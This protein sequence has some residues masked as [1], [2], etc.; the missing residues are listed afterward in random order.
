MKLPRILIAAGASGS[1]K[2]LITCGILQA[3][4]NRGKK[5]ASFKCGPD[6]IDP[7]FHRR[8]IG[9]KAGNLDAFFVSG[10]P[11][12]ELLWQRSQA[13]D[14]AVIEG[15]MG[16]Y[17]GLGG[18]L[19][20]GSSYD[21]ARQ[22]ETPVLFV[23]NCRGMSLSILP[24]IQGFCQFRKDNG[25]GGILLNQISPMIYEKVKAAI[26][27]N[28]GL[29]VVGYLPKVEEYQI[30]S[31]HLGL[32][33]PDEV[34]NLK[35]KLMGLAAVMEKTVDFPLLLSIAEK[36]PPLFPTS[37]K[38]EYMA[39][40]TG[41]RPIRVAVARD[42]AFCFLYEENLDFLQKLGAEILEFSPLRDSRLPDDTE[43]LILYG[44]Y[45]ELFAAQL[46]ENSSLRMEI[47]NRCGRERLPLLAEC[48]GFMYLHDRMADQEGRLVQGVG[49][50]SGD[51]YKTE[52][53]GRFGYI[54]LTRQKEDFFGE[55]WEKVRGTAELTAHEFHYFDST[56]PGAGFLARKPAGNRSWMCIH[57]TDTMLAGFPHFYY[58]GNPALAECFL[59]KCLDYRRRKE[60]GFL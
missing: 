38:E 43:G 16:Y 59:R 57:G 39:L 45:P 15:V 18:I 42:Q 52:K 47:R 27:E 40:N 4:T 13:T 25:I 5:I 54:Q 55:T 46:E 2:T 53:L 26:E 44:G 1:G 3:L 7:M 34:G 9:T 21:I 22:T 32:V 30:E 41:D 50:I 19:T 48:G 31:R 37:P 56:N 28:T 23:V 12:R 49:L 20:E 11:L 17:D 51:A 24:Y 60:E 33:M 36:A 29:P 8:V 35:G 58:Y 10:D 14:M 6:Y